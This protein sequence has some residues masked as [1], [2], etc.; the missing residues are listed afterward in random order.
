[1]APS[2]LVVAR[3]ALVTAVA[4]LVAAAAALVIA[5]RGDSDPEPVESADS[6]QVEADAAA[7]RADADLAVVKAEEAAAMAVAA[8][9]AFAAALAVADGGV[10]T[11]VIVRL[12]AQLEE[13]RADAAVALAMANAAAAGEEAPAPDPGDGA[14]IEEA[15]DSGD[16]AAIE[17][18]PDSG[19]G[20][21][22]EE[23]PD[24]GDGA[25]VGEAPDSGDGAAIEE[26]PDAGDAEEAA[27]LP[28]EPSESGPSE[29]AGLAVVGI[30]YNS[31]L[32]VR[33][34]PNGEIV[35][36]LDNVMDGA[37]TP[38]VYVRP[39]NTDDIL[40]VVDL[41]NGVV[42]TGNTRMLRTTVWHEFRAGEFT[43][44]STAAYLAQ[45]GVTGDAT[46]E[47]VEILGET[48]VADTMAGLAD[49]VGSAVASQEPSARV[50]MSEAPN[51]HEGLAQVAVDVV[52]IG[53]DSVFGYRLFVFADPA[54]ED[55]MQDD[56]GPYTLTSVERVV[57]CSSYRGV[58]EEGLCL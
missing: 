8:E 11:E 18:A 47:I 31:A 26:V 58:S 44:W 15:P 43:G 13:A 25:A 9:E 29:G 32:N 24:S 51:I 35:V 1:M 16:G 20:A 54:E 3:R 27:A 46:A 52:G 48:P 57:L 17:E 50:V 41:Y 49:A 14:A 7:A 5:F 21:A 42:A 22:V 4:A 37:R 34:V 30:Q 55:W 39:P 40:A 10:P 28:G 2:S 33:D 6:A 23:A 19:D 36:R 45:A 38:G 56:P 12:E 53:D